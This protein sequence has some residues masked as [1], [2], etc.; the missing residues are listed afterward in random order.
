MLIAAE[1]LWMFQKLPCAG[2]PEH[3]DDNPGQVVGELQIQLFWSG[4]V[5]NMG[6]VLCTT[7]SM[8]VVTS[9]LREKS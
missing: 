7:P 5:R 4:M 3:L 8:S 9:F 1:N 6:N 2:D